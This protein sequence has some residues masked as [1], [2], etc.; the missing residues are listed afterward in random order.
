MHE[1]QTQRWVQTELHKDFQDFLHR[2][3]IAISTRRYGWHKDVLFVSN[4]STINA[5]IS[6][7]VFVESE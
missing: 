4:V 3:L 7:I 2:T 5:F 1:K 6:E